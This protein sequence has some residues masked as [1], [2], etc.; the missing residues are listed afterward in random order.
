MPL[1]T[2]IPS[3]IPALTLSD[4]ERED[5]S[6][7]KMR[8]HKRAEAMIREWADVVGFLNMAVTVAKAKSGFGKETAKAKGSGQRVLNLSPRP[9]FEAGNRYNMPDQILINPGEGYAALA[10]YLPGHRGKAA[11]AA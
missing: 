7:Y 6:R 4:P 10:P 5:Y 11:K 9:T 2:G 8:L 3:V 1:L